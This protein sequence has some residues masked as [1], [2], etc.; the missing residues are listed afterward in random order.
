M[1]PY[2]VGWEEAKEVMASVFGG[3][4]ALVGAALILW[5]KQSKAKLGVSNDELSRR[6]NTSQGDWIERLE[7]RVEH[8]EARVQASEA[9][10]EQLRKE[11]NVILHQDANNKAL[12]NALT[13]QQRRDRAEIAKLKRM[14]IARDPGLRDVLD[15]E[16]GEF[17]DEPYA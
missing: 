6:E 10:E 13:E 9:R 12:I 16:H 7:K 11:F 8:S 1:N 2:F 17:K 5:A 14:L 3:S 15:S 4:L